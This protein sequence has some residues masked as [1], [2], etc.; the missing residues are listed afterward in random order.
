MAQDPLAAKT[1]LVFSA[2]GLFAA[3]QAGV[4]KALDGVF[5]PDLVVGASAGSLNAWAVAGGCGGEELARRWLN[6]ESLGSYRWRLAGPF[7]GGF[8]DPWPL[9][10]EIRRLHAA[11]H[12][13]LEV[14]VV[15]TDLYR[16]R[17][18]LFRGPELGWEHLAASCA[19]PGVLP[20]RRIEGRVYADGGMLG[21]LPLWAAAEMGARRIL[22][23]QVL[24]RL[25]SRVMTW[26]MRAWRAA[27]A[28]RTRIPPD[29]RVCL[30]GP[31]SPLGRT[32]HA[33]YWRRDNI[34]RWIG[35]GERDARARLASAQ[36]LFL[37]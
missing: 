12:P 24:P 33:L 28:P 34:E 1:A 35:E 9:D 29:V 15:L 23:I 37:S 14:G 20:A 17:P 4:W 16:Q 11:F 26:L 21:A 7:P 2:G 22:A 3:Y 36:T 6:L 5:R 25:P 10:L 31:G 32:R 13:K 8:L 19:I 30:V 27:A 18:R